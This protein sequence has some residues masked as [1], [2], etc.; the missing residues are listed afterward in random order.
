[1]P[2]GKKENKSATLTLYVRLYSIQVATFHSLCSFLLTDY[3]KP[4]PDIAKKPKRKRCNY[5]QKLDS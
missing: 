2:L 4:C 5:P 3:P 1:M